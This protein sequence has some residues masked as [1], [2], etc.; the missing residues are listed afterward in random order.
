MDGHPGLLPHIEAGAGQNPA[1]RP[2]HRL[3]QVRR[4]L[5]SGA[6]AGS[7]R[8]ACRRSRVTAL[9]GPE[10]A[11]P[12]GGVGARSAIYEGVTVPTNAKEPRSGHCR[13]TFKFPV[14]P[15]N[16]PVPDV[17]VS[18]SA[19]DD[20][21]ISNDEGSL[22]LVICPPTVPLRVPT[23]VE[24]AKVPAKGVGDGGRTRGMQPFIRSVTVPTALLP[25]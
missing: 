1:Y 15:V 20:G 5:P 18:V 12:S 19:A 22:T 6:S 24:R 7:P 16:R 4:H 23:L 21:S 10:P 11:P 2:T 9:S 3:F 14:V 17:A 13:L 25:K 8:R